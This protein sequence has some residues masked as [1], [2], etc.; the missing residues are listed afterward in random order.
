MNRL[1]WTLPVALTA[2]GIAGGGLLVWAG[3]SEP[4]RAAVETGLPVVTVVRVQPGPIALTVRGTGAIE[5]DAEVQLAAQVG[6]PVVWTAPD[7]RIG[8][9]VEAGETLARLD[10]TAYEASVAEARSRVASAEQALRLEVGRG[11]VVQLEQRLIGA[12]TTELA[13]R[14]PQLASATADLDAARANLAKA[15]RDLAQ[16]RIRAPFDGLLVAETLEKGAYVGTGATVGRVVGTERMRVE[17]PVSRR[18]AEQLRVPGFNDD[19]GSPAV[20]R[21]PGAEGQRQATIVGF[22]GEVDASTRSVTLLV[23]LENP[24]DVAFGPV[25]VPGTFVEVEMLGRAVEKAVRLPSSILEDGGT[26]WVVDAEG[27]LERVPVEVVWRDG[28]E[29][30][31]RGLGAESVVIRSHSAPLRGAAVQVEV[32]S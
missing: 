16:T 4:A 21:V 13:Q 14:V 15:E 5:P 8:R 11:D 24:L 25:V 12:E 9:S 1:M 31:V 10:T 29:V 3:G 7:L 18:A 19:V 2:L 23:E 26:V 28:D 32:A 6:G 20:V 17:L 22:T 30:V 27:R